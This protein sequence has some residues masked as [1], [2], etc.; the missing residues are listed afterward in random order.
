[1][2]MRTKVWNI[3]L[4]GV[5]LVIIPVLVLTVITA[6]SYFRGNFYSS[7]D[8]IIKASSLSIQTDIVRGSTLS[9][10]LSENKTLI[11]FVKNREISAEE[12][13]IVKD[14]MAHASKMQGFFTAFLACRETGSYYVVRNEQVVRDQLDPNNEK[15]AWFYAL[16]DVPADVLYNL[17]YNKTLDQTL[18]WFDQ[19][20]YDENHKAIA[21]V[22]VAID[23]NSAV[24]LMMQSL[25]SKNSWG[26]FTDHE[27]LISISSDEK[28]LNKNLNDFLPKNTKTVPGYPDLQAYADNKGSRVLVKRQLWTTP[29][30]IMLSIPEND[31]IPSPIKIF[32]LPI[33]IGTICVIFVLIMA[34]FITTEM[35]KK[36]EQMKEAM[37]KIASLDLTP[38]LPSHANDEISVINGYVNKA[39]GDI[40]NAMDDVKSESEAMSNFS[41]KLSDKIGHSAHEVLEINSGISDVVR[42]VE[43]QAQDVNSVYDVLSVVKSTIENLNNRIEVQAANISN[44]TSAIT[45]MVANI[46]SVTDILQKNKEAFNGLTSASNAAL[47]ATNETSNVIQKISGDSEGLLEAISVIQNIATQTNLLAMNAAI[48]AA[49]AGDAGKGF[50]V[51]ADEIRK[52]AEESNSQGNS[53]SVVLKNLK[54]EIE[55]VTAQSEQMQQAFAEISQHTANFEQQEQ[56]IMSAMQEQNAGSGQILRSMT[57]ISDITGEVKA[58]SAEI[59]QQSLDSDKKLNALIASTKEITAV[60]DKITKS[61]NE[62]V[63]V[64][65]DVNALTQENTEIINRLTASIGRFRT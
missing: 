59:M 14:L 42:A 33:L 30:Y 48:E 56:T 10:S 4:G 22:G 28:Y 36:F 6:E 60:M 1:M 41:L 7:I 52:L 64:I 26:G 53:I 19:K 21:L 9:L 45:E 31:F 51:V 61:T 43:N 29:Y 54:T 50:A 15:D 25:P 17:D 32:G 58:G 27:G 13:A 44:S 12:F 2:K 55:N 40:R 16:I 34:G 65:E 47:S 63:D 24:N 62:V 39:L 5:I 20:V 38:Q 49:H 18:F 8:P 57:E 3:V 46:Q 23:L 35:F 37:Q 11:N